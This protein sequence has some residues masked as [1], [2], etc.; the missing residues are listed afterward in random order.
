MLW[1]LLLEAIFKYIH[2]YSL[3]RHSGISLIP[4]YLNDISIRS[5]WSIQV[6]CTN[7]SLV[8]LWKSNMEMDNPFFWWRFTA[9]N[10]MY[11]CMIYFA[12]SYLI[13]RGYISTSW[14][15]PVAIIHYDHPGPRPSGNMNTSKTWT[16]GTSTTPSLPGCSIPFY[17]PILDPIWPDDPQKGDLRYAKNYMIPK[18]CTTSRMVKKKL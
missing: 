17:V 8:V 9:G 13:T 15:I 2:W 5:Q 10:I 11:T 3:F 14:K 1:T 12:L 4:F 6:G 18:S 7:M 16:P